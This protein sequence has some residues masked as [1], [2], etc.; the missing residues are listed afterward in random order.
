MLYSWQMNPELNPPKQFTAKF[1]EK[2]EF[3]D[4]FAE[5]HFELTEPHELGFKSGQYV[6]IQVDDVGHRRSYSI[7]SSPATQH[8]IE[9]LID[10]SPGGIG[11]QYLDNLKFGDSVRGIGPMGQFV[12]ADQSETALV[13]IAT[14]SGIAP[15]RSMILDL[16]Q[17]RQDPREIVLYWG[18]RHAHELFWLD[19]FQGLVEQLPNFHFY[20]TLSQPHPEWTLST[21]RVTDL[22][23]AHEFRPA[24][25]FYL[26]GRANMIQ[27]VSKILTEKGVSPTNIHVEKFF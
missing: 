18:M 26:C 16:V 15:M 7:T 23:L 20:P 19:D 4:K 17:V 8:G 22:V 21:G 14:G 9:L 3:N 12:I 6:S 2:I 25:G 10:R 5:Y 27:D 24:T 11:S 1:E 13:F